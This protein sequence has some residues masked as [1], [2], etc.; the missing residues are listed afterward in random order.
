VGFFLGGK[1]GKQ[2]RA[3]MPI[4]AANVKQQSDLVR[5]NR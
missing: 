1:P 3:T 5:E 4:Q 2:N